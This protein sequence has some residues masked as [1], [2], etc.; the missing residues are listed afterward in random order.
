MKLK[1]LYCLCTKENIEKNNNILRP[2]KEVVDPAIIVL[3]NI[4][5]IKTIVLTFLPVI[6]IYIYE[7]I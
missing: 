2:T 7:T 4:V 1:I 6:F 5:T 3:I